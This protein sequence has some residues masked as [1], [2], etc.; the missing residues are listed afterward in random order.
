M[1]DFPLMREFFFC[2]RRR[3]RAAE[4]QG[5]PPH[6]DNGSLVISDVKPEDAG[7]YECHATNDIGAGLKKSVSL[8]V[9]GSQKPFSL[10]TKVIDWWEES[11]SDG[12]A[13]SRLNG[14]GPSSRKKGRTPQWK[15]SIHA[16]RNSG[17]FM[18]RK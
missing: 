11:P 6:G 4:D 5:P 7:R 16:G 9:H 14:G 17:A 10:R 3:T 1:S 12:A 18:F 2:F 8:S 15:L 13:A